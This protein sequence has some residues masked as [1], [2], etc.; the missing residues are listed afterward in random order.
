M[1]VRCKSLE[2]TALL[3]SSE[4]TE[5]GQLQTLGLKREEAQ[6]KLGALQEQRLAKTDEL[7]LKE[8]ESIN[9]ERQKK[10]RQL[11]DEKKLRFCKYTPWIIMII[12]NVIT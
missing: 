4:Q 10:A 5:K 8:D 6:S 3:E 12:D 9:K 2:T 11:D 7:R 1:T